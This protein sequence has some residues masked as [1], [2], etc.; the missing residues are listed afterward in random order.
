MRDAI[1]FT[2]F[3]HGRTRDALGARAGIGGQDFAVLD[4][5]DMGGV[6]LG[7][8]TVIVEHE[9]IVDAGG[10]GLD[11][12]E[13]GIDEIAGMDILV[14]AIGRD[15]PDAGGDEPDAAFVVDGWFVF[16]EYDQ[17]WTVGI[18]ASIHSASIFESAAQGQTDMDAVGHLIGGEGLADFGDN[19]FV[20][21]DFG[22]CHGFGGVAQAVEMRDQFE[23]SS[24]VEAQALPDGVAAL[25]GGIKGADA[26]DIAMIEFAIDVDQQVAVLGIKCLFHSAFPMML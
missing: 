10:I 21:W 18:E 20:R 4:D 2:D 16:G 22:K 14:D 11:L 25:D 19:R 7:D 3:E 5:E 8:V 17:G 12:G 1:P 26:G 15:A 13:D 9:G 23:D 24:V 6:G